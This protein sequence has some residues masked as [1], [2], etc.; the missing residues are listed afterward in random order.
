[1]GFPSTLILVRLTIINFSSSKSTNT[2]SQRCLWTLESVHT[3]TPVGHGPPCQKLP[4]G[5]KP[6]RGRSSSPGPRSI[7]NPKCTWGIAF[8]KLY[9]NLG[10]TLPHDEPAG[11]TS[12]S[13]TDRNKYGLTQWQEKSIVSKAHAIFKGLRQR[14]GDRR[15]SALQRLQKGNQPVRWPAAAAFL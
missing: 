8:V 6:E 4:E 12:M 9:T 2:Y 13:T 3:P 7:A 11:S 14:H 1:M 10:T 5:T 15:H